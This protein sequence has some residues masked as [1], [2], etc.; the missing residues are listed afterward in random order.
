MVRVAACSGTFR[1]ASNPKSV[2]SER[3]TCQNAIRSLDQPHSG[4]EIRSRRSGCL[5]SETA[6]ALVARGEPNLGERVV[7]ASLIQASRSAGPST[8]LRDSCL[9]ESE[10]M[11]DRRRERAAPRV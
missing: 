7:A 4:A 8:L 10:A 3:P 9:S 2:R 11:R 1:F 5:C 6:P